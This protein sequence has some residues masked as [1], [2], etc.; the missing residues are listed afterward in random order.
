MRELQDQGSELE[1]AKRRTVQLEEELS[2]LKSILANAQQTSMS[3]PLWIQKSIY[4]KQ[5]LNV[6]SNLRLIHS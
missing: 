6:P 3:P 4:F 1:Q 5:L 2:S